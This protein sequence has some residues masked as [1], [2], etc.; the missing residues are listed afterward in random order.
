[1]AGPH[2]DDPGPVGVL[3]RAHVRGLEEEHAVVIAARLS[4]GSITEAG[5]LIGYSERQVR[6]RW[7]QVMEY[8]LMQLGLPR[9]DEALIG[10]WVALHSGC[11]TKRAF[12]LLTS[13]ARFTSRFTSDFP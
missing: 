11:C 9:H 10:V 1:V 2:E 5:R 3:A 7:D 13:D 4:A 8:A 6:R 12:A